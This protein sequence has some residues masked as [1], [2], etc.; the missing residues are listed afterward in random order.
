MIGKELEAVFSELG[1]RQS[2]PRQ[3]LI[4]LLKELAVTGEGFTAE[5]LWAK[6]KL[7]DEGIGRATIFRAV[8]SLVERAVL[9]PVE[10]P[11]GTR[12]YR[13]CGERI[14]PNHAHHH[15]LACNRCHKIVAFPYCFDARALEEIAAK[16]HFRIAGHSITL[17]GLC[18]ECQE[19]R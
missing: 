3:R 12:L 4:G 5:D 10:F 9:D 2:A 18:N 11:D 14:A 6:V 15:H 8:K 16:E 7:Q 17:Y 19:T 13:V 1:Q